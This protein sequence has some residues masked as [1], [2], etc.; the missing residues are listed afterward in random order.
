MRIKYSNENQTVYM[1]SITLDA[2][3][4]LLNG[5]AMDSLRVESRLYRTL[6]MY[7]SF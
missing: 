2:P 4:E 7:Q 5:M 6:R 3:A 1:D